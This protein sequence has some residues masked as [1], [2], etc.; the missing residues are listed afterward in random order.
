MN[1]KKQVVY[2]IFVDR[3]KRGPHFSEKVSNGIYSRDGGIVREWDEIPSKASKGMEFFG[4]D[5]EGIIEELD[6][7]KSL[8]V[9]VLYLTPIFLA[10][11]NHKYDTHDFMVDPQFGNER[12]LK[13]LINEAHKRGIAI[14]L[15]GVF[16]HVGADGKW[17]NRSKKYGSGGAYNDKNSKYRDFFYFEEWPDKYR[18]WYDVKLLPEL[19]LQNEK[20]RRVLFTSENSVVKRYLKLGIDGWRLDCA[21]DLGNEVNELI[22]KSAKEVNPDSYVVGEVSTYPKAWLESNGLDGVMN[23][24]FANVILGGLKGEYAPYVVKAELDR[25]VKEIGVERLSKSWNM[26][27]SHDT[28]RLK[29]ILKDKVLRKMAVAFQ[30][31]FPGNPFLYYGEENGMDGGEDPDNRR[32]MV[33]KEEKWDEDFR[34]F[35]IEA[36]RLKLNEPALNGGNY[37]S[38]SS[39]PEMVAFARY[40]GI[41]ENI[42]F[43]FANFSS[44]ELKEEVPIPLSYFLSHS[45]SLVLLGKGEVQTKIT[46]L[47]VTLPPKSFVISKTISKFKNY[48]MFKYL[49]DS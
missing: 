18:G 38:L 43:F 4:G 15:D 41:P 22:R 11:T 48:R 46:S 47:E 32:P 33:W 20:V 8:R 49:Y 21:H 7:V 2:Q 14:L 26:L 29:R 5:L 44:K 27:S 16:N 17:F 31:A 24:Y 40:N 10:S 25:M 30:V 42:I 34:S 35:V 28:P 37:L 19:N 45:H 6:Y 23:Y 39:S 36:M 3:F 1:W 12:I 13:K 9:N